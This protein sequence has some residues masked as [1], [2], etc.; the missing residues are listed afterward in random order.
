MA[1]TSQEDPKVIAVG[2][3][4]EPLGAVNTKPDD[5]KGD[6]E[7]FISV[8]PDPAWRAVDGLS[9]TRKFVEGDPVFFDG[10]YHWRDLIELARKLL[11]SGFD[12]GLIERGDRFGFED[13]TLCILGV[14]GFPEL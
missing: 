1:A 7:D 6:F 12:D 2:A 14:G 13:F 4:I 5:R 8:H 3:N 11:K 10:G 9:F